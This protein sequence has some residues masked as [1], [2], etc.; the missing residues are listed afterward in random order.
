MTS[1]RDRDD[2]DVGEAVVEVKGLAVSDGFLRGGATIPGDIDATQHPSSSPDLRSLLRHR[3]GCRGEEKTLLQCSV[4][5]ERLH[6][7]DR[8]QQTTE[9]SPDSKDVSIRPRDVR[10]KGH[11]PAVHEERP[12]KAFERT[13]IDDHGVT[14]TRAAIHTT[15]LKRKSRGYLVAN[16]ILSIVVLSP[17]YAVATLHSIL[18]I[19][20]GAQHSM[21]GIQNDIGDGQ[22]SSWTALAV[23]WGILLTA[24]LVLLKMKPIMF[25]YGVLR[26]IRKVVKYDRAPSRIFIIRHGQSEGNLDATVYARVPDN[27]VQLTEEGRRQAM[28]AGRKL[29]ALTGGGQVRFFVSPYVRSRQTFENILTG[30]GLDEASPRFTF[31]EDP[32]LREQDWGNLQVP[33]KVV[34]CMKERRAFGSFYYRFKN[35]ESGADVYDRVTSF[36]ASLQR[37][38]KYKECLENFVIISH[39]ITARMLLMRYFKWT[40]DEYH[41]LFNPDNCEILC[42]ELQEDG[43]YKLVT[44]LRRSLTKEEQILA[45]SGA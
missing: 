30:M 1:M 22:E 10:E 11:S 12:S 39:G 23:V 21:S 7:S 36:W 5:E 20:T 34:Q 18:H 6:S 41:L 16:V 33:E 40:V 31:R 2:I 43:H 3:S 26:R 17:A 42:L 14:R 44:P 32:R 9:T 37:E 45:H 19:I 35:G 15:L 25:L 29:K 4:E 38:M 27:R 8:E 24:T 13:E 28:E